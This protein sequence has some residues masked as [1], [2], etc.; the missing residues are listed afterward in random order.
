MTLMTLVPVGVV[1]IALIVLFWVGLVMGWLSQQGL[2][3]VLR[4]VAVRRAVR[5]TVAAM[6]PPGMISG[7]RP[8][9]TEDVTSPAAKPNLTPWYS[10]RSPLPAIRA[11]AE[12]V[13]PTA[14]PPGHTTPAGARPGMPYYRDPS[15]GDFR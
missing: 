12:R 8:H 1:L 2:D 7:H 9:A 13:R 10:D 11:R 14:L 3:R 15:G 5:E 4:F 6:Q